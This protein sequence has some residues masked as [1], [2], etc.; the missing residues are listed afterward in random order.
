MISGDGYSL[1]G[2]RASSQNYKSRASIGADVSYASAARCVVGCDEHTESLSDWI[3]TPFFKKKIWM[4]SELPV[5]TT[6]MRVTT[7]K[8]VEAQHAG[9]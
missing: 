1:A 5:L 7:A 8:Q 3:W 9:C 2:E 6:D 4:S